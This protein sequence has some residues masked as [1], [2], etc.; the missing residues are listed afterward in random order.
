MFL[1][2]G[3]FFLSKINIFTKLVQNNNVTVFIFNI[4]NKGEVVLMYRGVVSNE[5]IQC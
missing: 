2:W 5:R 3:G 4:K 1:F